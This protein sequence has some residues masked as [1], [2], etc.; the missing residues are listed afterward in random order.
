[1]FSEWFTDSKSGCRKIHF[2][3]DTVK[4]HYRQPSQCQN[5]EDFPNCNQCVVFHSPELMVYTYVR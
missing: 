1:M 5:N 4:Q 3:H 2:F